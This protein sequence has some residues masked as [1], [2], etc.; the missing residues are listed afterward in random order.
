MPTISCNSWICTKCNRACLINHDI[1]VSYH[2]ASHPTPPQDSGKEQSSN[3]VG[4][5]VDVAKLSKETTQDIQAYLHGYFSRRAY[6]DCVEAQIKK[7]ITEALT[8]ALAPVQGELNKADFVNKT[9]SDLLEEQGKIIQ[10]TKEELERVK[11]LLKELYGNYLP[12]EHPNCQ[13]CK[14][15]NPNQP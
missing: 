14:A 8:T 11:K 1:T 13:Y 2:D 10:S 15:L 6:D 12:D 4:A 5:K 9:Q 3:L 7:T